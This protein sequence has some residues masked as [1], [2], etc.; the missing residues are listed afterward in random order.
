MSPEKILIVDIDSKSISLLRQVL[1]SAGFEVISA[2]KPDRAL[3]LVT[4][5]IPILVITE[6]RLDGTLD[7]FGL[8]HDIREISNIPMILLSDRPTTDDELRALENGAD[9]YLP[10]PFDSR[11]LLARV[12][13]ILRRSKNTPAAP[14]IIQCGSLTINQVSRQVSV[15]EV[16]VYLTE[17][18][19]N[20]LLELAKHPDQVM[21]HEQLL[22]EVWGPEY[23]HELDYLRSYVHILR[24]KLEKTPSQ[25]VL[26]V[27]LSGIGY[28]LVSN[29][30][31]KTKGK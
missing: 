7:G 23:R 24:K 12:K 17:T 18:E 9:D 26:I 11:I 2:N 25:P 16:A 22:R 13:S 19:Y 1:S 5:E 15:D 31:T 27:S 6:A 10:K 28:K 30:S 14:E 29:P 4:E 8:L 20:L 21:L 3:Q